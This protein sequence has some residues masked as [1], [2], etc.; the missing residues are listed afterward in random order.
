MSRFKWPLRLPDADRGIDCAE[1]AGGIFKSS[2]WEVRG[3]CD[4]RNVW[5]GGEISSSMMVCPHTNT[6]GVPRRDICT[7]QAF[8]IKLLP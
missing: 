7:T 5:G 4:L 2:A 8:T 1:L 6:V 3:G